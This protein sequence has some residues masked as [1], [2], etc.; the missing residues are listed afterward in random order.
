MLFVIVADVLYILEMWEQA[1]QGKDNIQGN[2]LILRGLYN[3]R[4]L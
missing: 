2:K 4:E 1:G 3:R